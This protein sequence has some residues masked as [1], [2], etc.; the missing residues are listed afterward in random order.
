MILLAISLSL[1]NIMVN[2]NYK[3]GQ[4]TAAAFYREVNGI[5]TEGD[6]AAFSPSLKLHLLPQTSIIM[7]L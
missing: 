1:Y 3:L 5:Y 4:T 2:R 6:D 7:V